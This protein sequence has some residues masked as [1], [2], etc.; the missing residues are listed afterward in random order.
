MIIAPSDVQ[1]VLCFNQKR[2]PN[3]PIV[4]LETAAHEEMKITELRIQRLFAT[5]EVAV[6]SVASVD[7]V[8]K[9]GGM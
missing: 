9:A 4:E 5:T 6:P 2:Y 3:R 8:T 7:P 1:N